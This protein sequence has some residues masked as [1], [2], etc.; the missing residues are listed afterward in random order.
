MR[1]PSSVTGISPDSTHWGVLGVAG[2]STTPNVKRADAKVFYVAKNDPAA[3]DDNG[4][5][6][7]AYPL[8]TIQQAID[9]AVSGRG[10]TI[11]IAPA[12]TAYAE[13]LTITKDFLTLC[14][15]VPGSYAKPDIV[16]AS[17]K[18]LYASTAQGLVLQHLRFAVESDNHV[19]HIEGNGWLIEDCVIDGDSAQAA[20]KAGLLLKGNTADD[21]YTASEGTIR[22]CLIRGSD[23]YGIAFQE[24]VAPNGV[25]VTHCIVE[26][27]RFID[28]V[29]ED[30]IALAEA[31]ATYS[32]QD[33]LFSR[34]WFM[35]KNKA[36]HIDIQTNNGASNT[37]NF[38]A[39]C[40][41]HDDTIDAT[42]V[43]IAGTGSGGAGGYSMDGVINWDTID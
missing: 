22:D 20:T 17:G 28:N 29:A 15:S 35:S 7:L 42:A 16:P 1:F 5:E 13:A 39:D 19:V 43:K 6:D 36:T 41:I 38:F 24:A 18:A 25:G 34:C 30:V 11:Y 21:S 27:V 26:R 10:D 8:A 14:G 40:Y 12:S 23:G 33:T 9:N 4:G 32:V 37:G 2:T 31:G 3:N